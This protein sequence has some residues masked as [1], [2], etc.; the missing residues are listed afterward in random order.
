MTLSK[1]YNTTK[2]E[3][4]ASQTFPFLSSSLSP[5]LPLAP[6]VLSLHLSSHSVSPLAS[7]VLLL[8]LFSRFACPPPSVSLCLSSPFMCAFTLLVLSS[9]FLSL[10]LRPSTRLPPSPFPSLHLCFSICPLFIYSSPPVSLHLFF[11]LHL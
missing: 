4:P 11:S 3:A 2:A 10:T 8:H 7:L 5:T 9:L 1:N 6:P